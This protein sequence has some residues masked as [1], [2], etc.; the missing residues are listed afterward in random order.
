MKNV[1]KPL[2]HRQRQA[3]STQRLIVESA[4][5]LFLEQGYAATTIDAISAKAGVAASTVY[6]VF[7]N[8]RGILWAI[9][10]AWH[11]ESGQRDIYQQALQES[12]PA[13]RLEL[14]AHAT[15]RQWETSATMMQIYESAAASDPEAAAELASAR[16]GR[17]EGI[18]KIIREM[19][20]ALHPDFSPEQVVAIFLALTRPEVYQELVDE[21]RWSPDEYEAWLQAT[22]K[23][24]LLP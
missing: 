13:R 5:D 18:G 7:K 23:Q 15:R 14:A 2:T 20:T 4:R 6:A 24:Q 19:A 12:D 16:A 9:R 17:R 10:Q 11:E 22:L 21:A 1:K 3:L 8:K